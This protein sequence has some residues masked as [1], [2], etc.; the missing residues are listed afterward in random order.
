MIGKTTW[1]KLPLLKIMQ[2]KRK[3]LGMSIDDVTRRCD[4]SY[5]TVKR[6]LSGKGNPNLHTVCEI[7][8]VLG[9]TITY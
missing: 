7:C 2:D 8:N 3:G 1:D 5:S 6:T 9:L 4:V